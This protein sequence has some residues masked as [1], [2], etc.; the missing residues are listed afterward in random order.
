MEEQKAATTNEIK[1]SSAV[2]HK[3]GRRIRRGLCGS[4]SGTGRHPNSLAG[5]LENWDVGFRDVMFE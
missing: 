5:V 1:H 4:I 2:T 3:R